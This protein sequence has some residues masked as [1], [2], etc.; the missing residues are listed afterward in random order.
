MSLKFKIRNDGFL[1]VKEPDQ[2]PI[3][4]FSIISILNSINYNF[5]SFSD[6]NDFK[7]PPKNIIIEIEDI[8]SLHFCKN[9]KTHNKMLLAI[10]LCLFL[11]FSKDF[12]YLFGLY[13]FVMGFEIEIQTQIPLSG[14][15]GSS[16]A[17]SSLLA[18]MILVIKDKI[19]SENLK[20]NLE[21]VNKFAFM[22]EH[23]FHGKPSGMDNSVVVFGIKLFLKGDSCCLNKIL[24]DL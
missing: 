12:L 16:A 11:N 13:R 9:S 3:Y 10:L 19:N 8:I 1:I 18:T 14:G 23:I 7:L 24:F 6:L 5:S 21:L 2:K 4:E 17:F 22:I 15:L 20:D